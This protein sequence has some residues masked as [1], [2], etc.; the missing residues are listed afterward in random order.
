MRFD[1]IG[2]PVGKPR[3]TQRDK[4]LKRDCVTRYF[5]WV[6]HAR[7]VAPK[8]LTLE[9][10]TIDVLAYLPMPAS[11]SQRKKDD[12]QGKPHR[13]KPDADN[14]L[15]AVCD[16]LFAKDEVIYEK[17]VRKFWDDGNGARVEIE[18]T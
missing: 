9:P 12:A 16:A 7:L 10:S 6:N 17:R 13:Y 2:E 5:A 3:M 1:V 18:V 11:W 14:I 15:K 4:W 8:N